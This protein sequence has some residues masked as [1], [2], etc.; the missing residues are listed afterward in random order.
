MVSF[1]TEK[2]I[3]NN[4]LIDMTILLI[5]F[6]I[7]FVTGFIIF[8][9]IP[10]LERFNS[11]FEIQECFPGCCES[12]DEVCVDAIE[13]E[14]SPT[15]SCE[16]SCD[17]PQ[18][19]IEMFN[20]LSCEINVFV[21]CIE[22]VGC[23]RDVNARDG[24]S[25]NTDLLNVRDRHCLGRINKFC[26][27]FVNCEH[28]KVGNLLQIYL[29]SDVA[30]FISYTLI[31][32]NSQIHIGGITSR[33][34]GADQDSVLIPA[35]N[36]V[37]GRPYVRIHNFTNMEL[38]LNENFIINPLS[39]ERFKGRDH[40]GVRLG[41][42]FVDNGLVFP[43][44]KMMVPITD[45]YFGTITEYEQPSYGGWQM[46]EIFNE[47]FGEPNFLLQEGYLSGP[48]F[49]NIDYSKLPPVQGCFDLPVDDWGQLLK[50]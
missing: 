24:T 25:K 18:N 29:G 36:A 8:I 13:I 40:L 6:L 3:T 44:Y 21:E 12:G 28:L 9:S 39:I 14:S 5:V 41:T 20:H 1:Q 16:S 46:D 19:K 48:A 10:P 27:E 31:K 45:I 30:P 43:K 11:D 32:E 17:L 38:D 50:V 42:V 2:K 22:K 23:S 7:I 33:W 37:Q 4:K 35:S 15:L 47:Y 49:P 34:I 26:S